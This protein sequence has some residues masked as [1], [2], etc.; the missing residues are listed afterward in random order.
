M[1]RMI[2]NEYAIIESKWNH[3]LFCD[4]KIY[5]MKRLGTKFATV[6][7]RGTKDY[8]FRISLDNVIGTTPNLDI[9]N[10]AAKE[11]KEFTRLYNE[12]TEKVRQIKKN[13]CEKY[14]NLI[15]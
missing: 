15:E 11:S 8:D 13:F 7:E 2:L 12:Y 3:K 9:Y 1:K 10:D 5:I 14:S 6:G 4:Q